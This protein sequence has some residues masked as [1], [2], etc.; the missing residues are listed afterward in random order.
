MALLLAQHSKSSLLQRI[1]VFIFTNF[2]KIVALPFSKL[3]ADFIKANGKQTPVGKGPTT[4]L[5]SKS[6]WE[7]N[8][9]EFEIRNPEWQVQVDEIV[10][11]V[12]R[13]LGI[14]ANLDDLDVKLDKL[15]MF[16]KGRHITSYTE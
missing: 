1:L 15:L 7:L 10:E 4:G 16:G 8:T 13:K 9:G 6:T 5:K 14:A 3:H 11:K 2:A 12:K